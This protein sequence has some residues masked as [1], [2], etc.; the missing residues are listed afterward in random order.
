MRE[1]RKDR[2][3]RHRF[4]MSIFLTLIMILVGGVR[5]S[6]AQDQSRRFTMENG[7]KV[8]LEENRTAPVVALQIWAKVGSAD[9]RDEEAGM[10]HFIEHMIFKGTEKRKVRE[11][12]REIESLGG[13]IN[14]YTSYDQTVY[15]IAI[16]SRY[17]DTA[18][19]ILADAVQ[20]ST[21]DPLE[22]ERERE[23]ILE[24]IRMGKDNPSNRLFNQT[25]STLFQHHPYRRPII[26]FDKT[27]KSIT[28]DQMVS[29]FKRWYTPN[30][31]VL[32]AVGDFNL[33]EMEDKLKKTFKEFKPS[34]ESLP[35]RMEEPEQ[36][37]VRSVISHENFKETYLQIAFPIPSATHEDT[38][39]LDLLSHILGGGE[40]SRLVQ[41]IKLEKGLVHSISASSF[42]PKDPG[43]FI[44]GA[45]LPAENV[46]KALE[47]ILKEVIRL[48]REGVTA[49]EL[50]RIKVNIESDLIYDRQTVQG[51]ARK[52]GYYEVIAGDVQFEKEYMR[53]VRHLRS[54]DIQKIVGEYFQNS[55]LVISLLVPSEKADFLKNLSLKSIVEKVRFDESLVEK[56]EKSPV[57]KTVLD[58]GVRLIVKENRSI[59]IVS[60]QASF[61]GGVRF[62]KEAQN[63]INQFIAVMVTKGTQNH[64][65]LEIAKKVERMAGSINGFSGYNSFGLTF[66][67]LSQH[68]EEAFSLFTEVIK[69]PSFDPEEMEKRRRLILASIRQQEDD[70]GRMVFKLFRK[71]LFEK[72]PYRMDTLGTLDSI[73]SLTQKDL[74]E[75]YQGIVAPENMVITVVGDVD[76]NQVVLSVKKG[77]DD[78]R[79]GNLLLPSIPQEK[80]FQ[81]I[82]RSEI[83]KEKE[84]GHFVLGF[85]G[86]TLQHRDRCALEVLDAALSGQGGRL[87]Y[88][89]RDKESL[90]YALDFIA[91][92]N[93]DPG[94]IGVYM[95]THP[96]KL[97]RAI[98]GVLRELKRVKEEGLKEEEVQRAKR[99]LIGNFE[100]GLQ[101]NGAQANQMSLDELYGLGFDHY[102][103]YPQEIQKIT[104]EDVHQV[105]KKYFNLEAYSL[106][107]IRPPKG[108]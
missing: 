98:E 29:F 38:P 31:M 9:E 73:Q 39:G 3:R 11:M 107:I 88:E 93:L 18:L 15:H 70:L 95:G 45:T 74:K 32:I 14:A 30:R 10:C 96:D 66:T 79:K 35:K 7:L 12:A 91:N 37:G 51:Q 16:A 40:A 20:H 5:F 94:Y 103:K 42:T 57:F 77:V 105:A 47:A 27:V 84:Q 97:E 1:F 100:I 13:Y 33:Y 25:M 55:R 23:V 52:I 69:Q 41:K 54:E 21:F 50:H 87:F 65:S 2:M 63:G 19:D 71:T 106:A 36:I 26:G 108:K 104:G 99:Y 81:K 17:A 8:I 72:H 24:E 4:F 48:G 49:E 44:I 86:T 90:A 83:Y 101:T 60:I 22:L 43:L 64:S 82:K 67:F 62:E 78:L 92:P 53:R 75:Y 56:K 59:P 46:E 61:L 6:S 80:S 58:N 68:F 102:Q 85:L 28:K 76:S 34:S 89:L